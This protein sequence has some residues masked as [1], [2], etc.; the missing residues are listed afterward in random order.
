MS[1]DA[2]PATFIFWGGVIYFSVRA[3]IN[4]HIENTSSKLIFLK[5]G[6]VYC[7]ECKYLKTYDDGD[8]CDECLCPQNYIKESYSESGSY[9]TR[10]TTPTNRKVLSRRPFQ[11]NKENNCQYF[12]RKFMSMW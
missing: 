2:N 7:E 11:I 10:P 1:N 6:K 3:L 4:K 5:D 12:Q 8:N 9:M